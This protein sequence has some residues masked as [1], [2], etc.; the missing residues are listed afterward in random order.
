MGLFDEILCA[1][2]LGTCFAAEVERARRPVA[3]P[4]AVPVQYWPQPAARPPPPQEFGAFS[5]D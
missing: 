2:C 5:I 4:V 1:A 3:V